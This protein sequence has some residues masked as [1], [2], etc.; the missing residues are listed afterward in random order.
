M[1]FQLFLHTKNIT[2]YIRCGGWKTCSSW[3]KMSRSAA[4]GFEVHNFRDEKNIGR[5][6]IYSYSGTTAVTWHIAL[7]KHTVSGGGGELTLCQCNMIS[8]IS[9][10]HHRTKRSEV[11][12][13]HK[14]A[15]FSEIFWP[16]DQQQLF[17]APDSACCRDLRGPPAQPY[18]GLCVIHS[19]R[20][21]F[22]DITFATG[23]FK[24]ELWHNTQ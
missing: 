18:G 24:H 17:Q 9:A 20:D 8:C 7:H 23:A 14:G 3:Q 1:L 19:Q 22:L 5:W 11:R 12:R 10:A 13:E 4:I 15:L 2:E 16:V 6:M 21:T